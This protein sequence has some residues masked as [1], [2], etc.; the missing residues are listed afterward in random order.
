MEQRLPQRSYSSSRPRVVV[1]NGKGTLGPEKVIQRGTFHVKRIPESHSRTCA[2]YGLKSPTM[3]RWPSE[4]LV[5][6][7][8]IVE[9]NLQN[10]YL[11]GGFVRP[12][13]RSTAITVTS[14][15][16]MR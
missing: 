16:R 12:M 13:S 10:P 4:S 2:F 3:T 1:S 8:L 9:E 6:G 7:L 11:Y 14:N 15:V 5:L